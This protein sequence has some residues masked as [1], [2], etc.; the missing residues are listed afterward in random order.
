MKS[1]LRFF[2]H[3]DARLNSHLNPLKAVSEIILNALIHRDY[4][5][6]T[7]SSPIRI[8]FFTD[9]LEIENPG[10]LYGRSTLDELG[11]VGADTRNPS[12]AAALKIMIDTE[13]RFSCIPTIRQEMKKAQ[14]PTPVFDSSRGVFRV[15]L[16]ND[17]N[18]PLESR[19]V[20]ASDT[21]EGIVAFCET[22]RTRA[23]L[24]AFMNVESISY[25]MEK[26]INPLLERGELKMT[27]PG[28]PRSRN[29]KYCSE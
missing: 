24:S 19:V 4:S 26:Y 13:N 16:C 15:T 12:I 7:E 21:A 9:R 20:K 17:S 5:I 14:L 29:Q 18:K 11:K 1:A 25:M 10:G 27:I 8:M 23:E 3:R 22:P 28:K 2:L 6:H